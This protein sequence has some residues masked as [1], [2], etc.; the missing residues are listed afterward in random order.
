MDQ[1]EEM[2]NDLISTFVV[3]NQSK[4]DINVVTPANELH[5][6]LRFVLR[7]K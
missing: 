2:K 5:N 7:I 3:V 1:N 4:S 6:E